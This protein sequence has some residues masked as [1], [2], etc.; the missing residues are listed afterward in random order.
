MTIETA[1]WRSVG[2]IEEIVVIVDGERLESKT[3]DEG[4]DSPRVTVR[5]VTHGVMVE[6][7]EHLI[8][9][10]TLRGALYKHCALFVPLGVLGGLIAR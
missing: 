2:T 1:G 10:R 9:G 5:V 4:G 8:R 7:D 3:A 6:L